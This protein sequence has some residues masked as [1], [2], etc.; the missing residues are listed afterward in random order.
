MIKQPYYFLNKEVDKLFERSF[1]E[2]DVQA[3]EEHCKFI[4]AFIIASGWSINEY[5]AAMMGDD[6]MS[7]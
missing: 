6:T 5:T 2:K 3:I 4:E 7:N 1:D